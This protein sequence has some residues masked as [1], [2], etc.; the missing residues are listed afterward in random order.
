MSEPIVATHRITIALPVAQCQMLFT[1]AGEELWVEG[2]APR[3]LHPADG[4]TVQGMVFLT[5]SGDETTIWCLTT[6]SRDPWC[7]RY[8]RVTPASRWCHVDVVCTPLGDA[9]TQV[10]VTY[11]LQALQPTATA[12]LDHFAPQPF[13]AMID[14]WKR[15]IDLKLDALRSAVIR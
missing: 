1:P 15:C 2:W 13:A 7:A 6:F 8:A 9:A 14:G 4:R 10:A 11:T 3:Y 5:G 12:M